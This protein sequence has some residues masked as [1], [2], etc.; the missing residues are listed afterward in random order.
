VVIIE[1]EI[2]NEPDMVGEYIFILLF[3]F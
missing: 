3:V 1:P 2:V